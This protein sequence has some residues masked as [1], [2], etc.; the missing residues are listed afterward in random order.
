MKINSSILNIIFVLFLQITHVGWL[1]HKD[2]NVSEN[3]VTIATNKGVVPLN[4][5]EYDEENDRY[6]VECINFGGDIYPTPDTSFE[7][8]NK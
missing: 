7:V 1:D 4:V 2:V 8:L 3:G 5:I 6:L